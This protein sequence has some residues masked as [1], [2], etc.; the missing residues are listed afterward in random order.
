MKHFDPSLISFL[1]ESKDDNLCRETI[2][3]L[4][5]FSLAPS[6]IAV[7][8]NKL[9]DNPNPMI[10][11]QVLRTLSEVGKADSSTIPILVHACKPELPGNEMGGSYERKFERFLAL[12][13]LEQ[14]P[15]ELIKF[16][17]SPAGSEVPVGNLIWSIQALPKQLQEKYFL[18]LWPSAGMKDL[19][20][21]TF[22]QVSKMLDNKKIYKAIK[23]IVQ[24]SSHAARYLDF[25]LRNQQ[26]VQSPRL[27]SLLE[28]PVNTLLKSDS[29][30]DVQIA[31]EAVARLKINSSYNSIDAL[32]NDDT[33]PGILKLAMLALENNVKQNKL[34]FV[35]VFNNEKYDFEVRVAALKSISSVD[36][37]QALTNIESW[38]PG[39]NAEEKKLLVNAFSGTAHGS[40]ILLNLY[41]KKLL[42]LDNFS[43]G[44]A[45][46]IYNANLK[47]EVANSL[48]TQARNRADLERRAYNS[49]KDSYLTIMEKEGGGATKGKAIFEASCL[50]CHKVGQK[51]QDIAPALDGSSARSN[52]A[53]I[54][55]IL[56]PDAAVEGGYAV[57]RV[58]KKD[59]STTERYLYKQD[60]GGV[61]LAFMGGNKIFIE[62]NSIKE[63]G[64][65]TGRSFMPKGLL[66]TY[67][68]EEVADLFAYI[69]SLK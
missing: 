22:I 60:D 64:F 57:Y 35:R 15:E 69:R 3:S 1:L 2:R 24:D 44:A 11:S 14:Y 39:M 23:D 59:N 25:A 10:R 30:K 54:T 58:I 40:R 34:Q 45:E 29:V 42:G 36:K 61:T 50:Q 38:L 4:A 63:Q 46:R 66:E 12:K 55:A 48:V 27:S 21:S 37:N 41:Q 18:A 9:I 43:H 5:S 53:L 8:C 47:D 20:E 67:S 51:G 62:N 13:A 56:N 26:E 49:K 65:I 6:K 31:L 52:E 32:I 16:L 19:D 33:P 17:N 7:A 28:T 68:E